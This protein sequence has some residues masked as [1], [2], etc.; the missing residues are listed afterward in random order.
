MIRPYV[1]DR[2]GNSA[3][4]HETTD[5]GMAASGCGVGLAIAARLT[6]NAAGSRVGATRTA[7][8]AASPGRGAASV[9]PAA[10]PAGA[11]AA[12]DPDARRSHR[13]SRH[14]APFP[15]HG[16]KT[17]GTGGV[18]CGAAAKLRGTAAP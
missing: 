2:N 7:W 5:R 4:R 14:G 12:P 9:T 6:P 15:R 3:T 16:G 17:G 10:A 1:G 11:P 8:K 13:W 18:T